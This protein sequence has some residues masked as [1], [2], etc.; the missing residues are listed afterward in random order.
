MGRGFYNL[1]TP[2]KIGVDFENNGDTVNDMAKKLKDITITARVSAEQKDVIQIYLDGMTESEF[3]REAI[4]EKIE[5]MGGRWPEYEF[6][7][8]GGRRP[9]SGRK[10]I[11]SEPPEN[12]G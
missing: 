8:H 1:R 2:C 4:K 5:R 7:G 9:G 12:G 6:T 11:L 3:A 10:R